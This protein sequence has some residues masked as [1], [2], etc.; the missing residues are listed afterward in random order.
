MAQKFVEIKMTVVVEYDDSLFDEDDV[1]NKSVLCFLS[2]DD[3]GVENFLPSEK[4]LNVIDYLE[5]EGNDV[6]KEYN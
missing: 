2:E 3:L 5:T 4:G 1:I 6:T